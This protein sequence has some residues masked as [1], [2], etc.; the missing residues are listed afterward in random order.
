VRAMI[1][2]RRARFGLTEVRM[3]E[4]LEEAVDTLWRIQCTQ[5]EEGPSAFRSAMPIPLRQVHEGYGWHR[6]RPSVAPPS[7]AAIDRLDLVLRCVAAALD[8]DNRLLVWMRAYGVRWKRIEHQLGRGRHALW[9]QWIIALHRMCSYA[10]SKAYA[11]VMAQQKTTQQIDGK[12][13]SSVTRSAGRANGATPS[14]P[15]T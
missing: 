1:H 14:N 3:A 5:P 7:A 4:L 8:P 6:A 11:R 2:D 13:A 9:R 10:Q 15:E 12:R